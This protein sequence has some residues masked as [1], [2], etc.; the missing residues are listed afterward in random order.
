MYLFQIF[1]SFFL[2]EFNFQTSFIAFFLPASCHIC[3]RIDV[4][5]EHLELLANQRLPL[6]AGSRESNFIRFMHSILKSLLMRAAAVRSLPWS[7]PKLSS[8]RRQTRANWGEQTAGWFYQFGNTFSGTCLILL[9]NGKLL[10]SR[11]SNTPAETLRCLVM[12]TRERILAKI[13]GKKLLK[14]PFCR[15]FKVWQL[16]SLKFRIEV[17]ISHFRST[18]SSQVKQHTHTKF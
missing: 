8:R 2:L 15:C 11:K 3:F 5:I 4:L 16:A 9:E 13:C 10:S 18:T 1:Y 17:S 12:W 14:L 7:Q 6:L